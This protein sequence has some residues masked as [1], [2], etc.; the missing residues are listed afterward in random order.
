MGDENEYK[1]PME[2]GDILSFTPEE[3]RDSG[4]TLVLGKCEFVVKAA[5]VTI[6]KAGKPMIKL[7]CVLHDSDGNSAN[8]FEYIVATAS[9]KI[10][11]LLKS[12][13]M[14]D[15]YEKGKLSA[16]SLVGKSG[17]CSINK[18]DFGYKIKKYYPQGANTDAQSGRKEEEVND[19]IPF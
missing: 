16:R 19:V 11:G 18:D 2:V 8:C 5:T 15:Q 12:V 17:I 4:P 7:L 10:E 9:W 3:D 6:S 14:G 1:E 13:G